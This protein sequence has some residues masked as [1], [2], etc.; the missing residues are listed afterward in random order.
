MSPKGPLYVDLFIL[1]YLD[2][3]KEIQW[4]CLNLCGK[5]LT[6]RKLIF[7]YQ[8]IDTCGIKYVINFGVVH[9][10]NMFVQRK[11]CCW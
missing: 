1:K 9:A 4:L 11:T 7:F 3:I 5:Y 8:I 6:Q 2:I 10:Y